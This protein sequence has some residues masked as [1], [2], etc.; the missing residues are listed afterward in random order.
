MGEFVDVTLSRVPAGFHF[1]EPLRL[2]LEWIER[3]GYVARGHDGDLYGDLDGGARVGTRIGFCGADVAEARTAVEAWFG[4]HGEAPSLWPFAETGADGSTA[5]LWLGIDG[6]TRIVHLGSGSGSL[7]TCVLAEDPVDFL[8]LLAIGYPE[9]CWPEDFAA[10]PVATQPGEELVN[11]P[12]RDWVTSTFGVTI[13]RT[14][15]EVVREPAELG[16]E[17]TTDPFCRLANRLTG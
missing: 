15:L 1:A 8:R 2:L 6:V 11:A 16:D 9:I 7:L 10:P 12:Y 14:A 17:T 13:P 4:H 5:A 3:Q